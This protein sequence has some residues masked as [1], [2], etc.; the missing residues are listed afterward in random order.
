[1]KFTISIFLVICLIVPS[2]AQESSTKKELSDEEKIYGL[3]LLW[4]EASYNFAHFDYVPNLDWDKT[5]QEFI[6]KVLSTN[7][8][9]EY[10]KTLQEFYALLKH[11]HT[12]VI[13][14][15]KMQGMYDEPEIKI[16]NVQ[17]QPIVA[18]VGLSL[19]DQIPIGS[20]IIKVD[21]IPVNDY[22]K[23]YKFP[24]MSCS[25]EEFLWE[26]GIIELLKGKKD[27][28][29]KITY[30]T[31]EN[32]IKEIAPLRNSVKSKGDWVRQQNDKQ[33][34][35]FKWL[36]NEIAYIALRT[37]TEKRIVKDFEEKISELKKCKGLII[38]IRNNP[39]GD[40]DNGYNILKHFMEYPELAFIWKA[41]QNIS[42]YK[43]WG[44]WT[45]ELS[46]EALNN[47]PEE[48]KEYVKHYQNKGFFKGKSDTIFP[49]NNI[50]ERIIVLIVILAGFNAS[51]AEDFLAVA[52]N[53]DRVTIVGKTTAGCTGTPYMFNIPTGGIAF[54]TTTIQMSP[55]GRKHREGIKPDIE[56]YPTVQ[57][58]IENKDPVLEKG[59]EI[60]KDKIK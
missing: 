10:N 47:I 41:R 58:I 22:L 26:A 23:K 33:N 57:D 9:E 16:V 38:D 44:R 54:V 7:T 50:D 48:R 45:S 3:S 21:D 28:N 14:P 43:A 55:D 42:V 18:N 59:I 15:E 30:K 29:V 17:N 34:F 31:P 20:K 5:Y 49:V 1:M 35:D 46:P 24:Y 8:N 39:G 6:P 53:I 37:F 52:D 19:Q 56:V 11:G 60:L 13:T 2:V 32:E 12:L 4:K 51:A 27:T 40:S 25:R 36:D